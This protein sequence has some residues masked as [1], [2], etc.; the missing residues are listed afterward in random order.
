MSE[1]HLVLALRTRVQQDPVLKKAKENAKSNVKVIDETSIECVPPEQIPEVSLEVLEAAPPSTFDEKD[2]ASQI[3]VDY[4]TD[5]RGRR[6]G[7]KA[8][9]NQVFN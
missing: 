5:T 9:G 3:I 8:H 7:V 6:Y 4:V 1:N 2:D